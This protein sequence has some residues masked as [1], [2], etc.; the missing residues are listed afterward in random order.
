MDYKRVVGQGWDIVTFYPI[1]FLVTFLAQLGSLTLALRGLTFALVPP[2]YDQLTY[3]VSKYHLEDM[4]GFLVTG[5][6]NNKF[7]IAA[8]WLVGGLVLWVIS[9]GMYG[10]LFS[11]ISTINADE[12]FEQ[13]FD[14]RAN[15]AIGWKNISSLL[16]IELMFGIPPYLFILV[17]RGIWASVNPTPVDMGVTILLLGLFMIWS[18]FSSFLLWLV[19]P[20]CVLRG[21][22]AF[23]AIYMAW[24]LGRDNLKE[25]WGLCLYLAPIYIALGVTSGVW[26]YFNAW[27]FP[28]SLLAQFIFIPLINRVGLALIG[29]FGTAVNVVAWHEWEARSS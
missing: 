25:I 26:V 14:F 12:D 11:G 18:L 8:I 17:G 19:Y 22:T 6:P 21:E 29:A 15:W 5:V 23:S 24:E 10:T 28:D 4:E 16:I 2:S 3:F 1:L 7:G 9:T 13:D 20:F 27:L